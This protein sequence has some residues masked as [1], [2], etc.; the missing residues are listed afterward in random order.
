[1]R[2]NSIKLLL[3]WL[4]VILHFVLMLLLKEPLS[5]Y[6]FLFLAGAMLTSLLVLKEK[7]AL[8]ADF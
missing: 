1:M 8:S 2:K 4:T 7:A 6:F 3:M 5:T